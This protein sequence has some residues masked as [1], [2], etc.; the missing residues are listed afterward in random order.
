MGVLSFSQDPRDLT[1]TKLREDNLV[2]VVPSSNQRLAKLKQVSLR[3]LA[4]FP[5]LIQP[6]GGSFRELLDTHLRDQGITINICHE[7]LHAEVLVG[8]V[9]HGLG[10]AILL[11]RALAPLNLKGCR[12][13]KLN[14]VTSGRV[15]LV[16]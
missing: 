11:E 8:L 5:F 6:R 15:G 13:L 14:E 9:G 3:Q 10:V 2:A 1:V 7:V 12:V 4:E 16:T